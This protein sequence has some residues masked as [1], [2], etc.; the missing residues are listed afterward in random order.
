MD[1]PQHWAYRFK[2]LAAGTTDAGVMPNAATTDMPPD[3]PG[4]PHPELRRLDPL[5]GTWT[6]RDRSI[7][8]PGRP[9]SLVDSD[10]R[11]TVNADGTIDARWC[12]PDGDGGGSPWRD[13]RYH[14]AT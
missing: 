14:L 8:G 12:L 6:A 3:R 2:R 1:G 7:D 11:I 13:V 4:P 5:I 9:N 10:G